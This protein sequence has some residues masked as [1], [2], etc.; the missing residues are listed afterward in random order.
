MHDSLQHG[1][2]TTELDPDLLSTPFG[3]QT[4]WHVITGAACSGKTTLID[5]LA[6]RGYRTV[7][8]IAR[9]YIDGEMAKERSLEEIL[10]DATTEPAM[11]NMQLRIEHELQANDVIFLDRAL[12]DSLTFRRLSGL[13]PNELL[14]DCFHHRYACIF[15]LDRLPFQQDS[16]RLEDD[17]IAG[18]IDEWLARDYSALGYN[19]VRVPALSIRDR[20]DFILEKLSE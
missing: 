12:P 20:L 9:Q 7:P 4:N 3:K 19:V 8:E 18:L 15:I 10:E 2:R 14:A 11:E 6:G 17:A 1:F 16:A 13:N 5:L